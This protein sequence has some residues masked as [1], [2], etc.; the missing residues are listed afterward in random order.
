[1]ENPKEISGESLEKPGQIWKKPS[2]SR[3]EFQRPRDEKPGSDHQ[4]NLETLSQITLNSIPNRLQNPTPATPKTPFRIGV[5]IYT[6]LSAP[7][8]QNESEM[9]P[10]I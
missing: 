10:E 3:R 9:E 8:L 5:P 1:M 2:G 6:F 7:E 4:G